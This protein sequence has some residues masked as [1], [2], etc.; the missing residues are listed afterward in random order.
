M[1][2]RPPGDLSHPAEETA[3]RRDEAKRTRDQAEEGEGEGD[4][5]EA[6]R[7]RDQAETVDGGTE[8]QAK[9]APAAAPGTGL[10]ESESWTCPACQNVNFSNRT[11]CNMR[12]CALP[13]PGLSEEDS[14]EPSGNKRSK[15]EESGADQGEGNWCD[16][17]SPRSHFVWGRPSHRSHCSS[18]KR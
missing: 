13:R 16:T 9:E 8:G 10:L 7:A 15:G 18:D 5:E 4:T 2:R 6:K 14:A 1:Q 11:R 17:H 3:P 12:R